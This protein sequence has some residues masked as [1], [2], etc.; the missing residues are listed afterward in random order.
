VVVAPHPDDETL[1]AGGIIYT[2]ARRQLPITI[3][4]VTDGEAACPEVDG[5]ASVR[6]EELRRA[7]H[8][9]GADEAQVVRLGIPDGRVHEFSTPLAQALRSLVSPDTTL[10]A[11]FEHDGHRDHDAT[12]SVAREIAAQRSTLLAAYPI[13]AWPNATPS[14]FAARPVVSFS[15]SRSARYAKRAAIHCYVSQLRDR[16]GGA[17]VPPHVLPYFERAY[18]AFVL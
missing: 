12:G 3:I 2:W 10:V 13:W 6:Q 16:P 14:V 5:L 18:E 15:L 11:P 8:C 4:S 17:I 7:L 1:G 9:L